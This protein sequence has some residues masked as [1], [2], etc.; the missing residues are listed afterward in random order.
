MSFGW[1]LLVPLS[2]LNIIATAVVLFYGWPLW[3]LTIVS[4]LLLGGTVYIIFR[5]PG[6]NMRRETVSVVSARDLRRSPTTAAPDA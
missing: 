4:L 6:T 2:F 3:S 5:N 1:K